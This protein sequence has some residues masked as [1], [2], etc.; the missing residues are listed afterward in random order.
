[1]V[2]ET[3]F[4]VGDKIYTVEDCAIKE[5]TVSCI[6]VFIYKDKTNITYHCDGNT[7]VNEENAF[8]SRE[9]L[10]YKLQNS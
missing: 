4:N 5:L 2:L 6:A 10:L 1:M 3:K 7:S 9:A 8:P